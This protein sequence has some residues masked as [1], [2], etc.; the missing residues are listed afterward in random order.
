MKALY[1]V[2]MEGIDKTTISKAIFN[3]VKDIYNA[4]CFVECIDSDDYWYTISCNIL[5]KI[6]GKS[7]PKDVKEAQEILKSFL[8]ENK[9][10]SVFVNVKN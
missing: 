7:I 4:L 10:I 9:S 6:K 5:Q 2:G 8:I 3:D 1:L